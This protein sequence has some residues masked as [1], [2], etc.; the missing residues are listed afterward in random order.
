MSSVDVA[1]PGGS[2]S[3]VLLFPGGDRPLVM[4]WPGLGMGAR[5]YRPIAEALAASGFPVAVGELRGQGASTAVAG[6]DQ[7]WG[8]HDLASQDYPRSIRGARRA[9]GLPEDHPTV[10]LTHS[11]GGQVGALF[12]ARPEARELNVRGM[13]GVGSGSPY[14]RT[15]PNPERSRLHLG[16]YVMQGVSRVLGYWPD[17][18]LDVTNYGRQSDVHLG[19]WARFGRSNRLS[20]LRGAD[21]DYMAAMQD[22]R[23]PVLLTRFSDDTYCTVDSCRALAELVPAEV[24]EFPGTLGHNSW[25]RHPDVVVD[26]FEAFVAS[27]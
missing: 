8:Y 6:K 7:Q 23:C 22:V 17:G 12:L 1:M 11:M 5:Y 16:G 10:L 25:A 18:R 14:F 19:E 21:M 24:E 26:R 15:F 27:L 4:L 20:D 13:M 2:T 3:P 9:L